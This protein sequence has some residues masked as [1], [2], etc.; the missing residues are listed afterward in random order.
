MRRQ[1]PRFLPW[2]RIGRP[3]KR[4]APEAIAGA[5]GVHF[6]RN[7]VKLTAAT[8][9]KFE[10]PIGRWNP[11]TVSPYASTATLVLTLAVSAILGCANA[12]VGDIGGRDAAAS[13]TADAASTGI[14]DL[15]GATS[16]DDAGQIIY[17][18]CDPFDNTGCSSGQ[19]CSALRNGSS[20]SLGCGSKGNKSE[21]DVCT[22]VPTANAQ[23]GDDCGDGLGC[24]NVGGNTICRRM[25][26]ATGS[27]TCPSG[28]TC[29]MLV[30]GIADPKFCSENTS[31]PP[32]T[33]CLPLEQS[34]CATG[35][36]CYYAATGSLCYK[37][38]TAQ[39]GAACNTGYDCTAG[40]TC[41]NINGS[42]ACHSFC[43]TAGGGTPSCSGTSTG[44]TFCAAFP[45]ASGEANLGFCRTPP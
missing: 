40:S 1:P 21:G 36:A 5:I 10:M 33:S 35:E 32:P 4:I 17:S 44:G 26:P 19:K 7:S 9:R 37:A 20:L 30:T 3:S 45:A 29:S 16:Q 15:T 25:C 39:P 18:P 14:P 6:R 28:K 34:G 24:F 31:P 2:Q 23:T 43:S 42:N 38:G 12:K 41:V 27:N 8:E 11:A 22:P 13:D